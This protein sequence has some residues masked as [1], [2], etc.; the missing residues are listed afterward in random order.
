MK[1]IVTTLGAVAVSATAAQAGGIDRS[2]QSIGILFEKGNYAEFSFGRVSPSVSGTGAGTAP[3]LVTPTPGQASGDMAGNYNQIGGGLKYQ[4]NDRVSAALIVDQ[5]FG[6]NVS[7]PVATTYFARGSTASIK[8][9]ALTG[10]LKYTTESNFSVYGGLKYQTMSAKASVPFIASY[11]GQADRDGGFGYVVGVAYEKPEIAL[12]VALTYSSKVKH[13]F[14]PVETS[15]VPALAGLSGTPNTVETPQ[16]VNLE[17]Q[18]GV[19]KDTLVFGSIRWVDW[20]NFQINPAMYS[21]LTGG[22]ALVSYDKDTVT[23]SLG[24]GRRLNENWAVS[25]SVGYEKAGGGFSANLGPTDGKKSVT[26]AAVYTRDNMKIT[27]GVTYVKIGDAQTTLGGGV[28]AANF[29]SNKAVGVGI[30]VG[31]SF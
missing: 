11:T 30:K 24:V 25:A 7:Y 14:S 13:N 15:A 29:T 26:L 23:Y 1:K 9:M 19:A 3:S 27:G 18:S 6:A 20:S 31:Y 12:R 8:T 10:L 4:I 28:T 17:F 21:A 16:S 22:A 5:P 2:G